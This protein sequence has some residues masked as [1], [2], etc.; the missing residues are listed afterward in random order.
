MIGWV[1][2]VIL[3]FL[4]EIAGVPQRRAIL[5]AAGLDEAASNFRLD[6]DV[7]D[8]ACRRLIEA[9]CSHLGLTEKQAYDAFAPYF[10]ARTQRDFPGF[11]RNVSG[12]RAFL[13]RQPSIHNCLA[14]GLRD[15]Q[16]TAVADKFR[17]VA[18]PGGVRVHYNSPNRMAALYVSVVHVLAR[19]YGEAA[20]VCFAEGHPEAAS[21]I[22]EVSV[23][24]GAAVDAP[25]MADA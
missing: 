22:M 16:R 3:D 17:V 25:Q 23:G 13:L 4:D 8:P 19:H 24:A 18:T 11:F 10:V 6:T 14:A 21:C 12:L 7:P 5:S 9:A 1:P 2:L 15:Q 20:A